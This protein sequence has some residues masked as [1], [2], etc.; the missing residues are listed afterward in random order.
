MVGAA[1]RSSGLA[2]TSV[3]AGVSVLVGGRSA[4]LGVPVPVAVESLGPQQR[5]LPG[6][7]VA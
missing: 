1:S 4:G 3:L 5:Q 7:V 2:Q 6:E